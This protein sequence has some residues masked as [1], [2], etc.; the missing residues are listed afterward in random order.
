MRTL[1]I[2][3]IASLTCLAGCGY[4][5]ASVNATGPLAPPAITLPTGIAVSPTSATIQS[6]EGVLQFTATVTPSGAVS[7]SVSGIGCA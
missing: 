4:S 1:V 6:S 7:W 2:W 5:S 3:G